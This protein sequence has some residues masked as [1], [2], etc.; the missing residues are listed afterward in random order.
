[1]KIAVVGPT[2]P[3][4]EGNALYVSHLYEMLSK[5]F[6]I[7]VINYKLLY[8]SFFPPSATQEDKSSVKIKQVPSERII[9]SINPLSWIKAAKIIKKEQVDLVVFDW[10]NSF[11]RPCHYTISFLLKRKYKKKIH[12]ITDNVISHTKKIHRQTAY[13]NRIEKYCEENSNLRTVAPVYSCA[14]P[15]E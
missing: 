15:L 7:K 9:N 6:D 1:M 8:L 4:S 14:D 3:Y 10:W 2:Y 11:F 12:F 13:T 5:N